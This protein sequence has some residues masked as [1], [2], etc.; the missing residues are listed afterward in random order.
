MTILDGKSYAAQLRQSLK[1]TVS[2]NGLSPT[3]CIINIGDDPASQVYVRNKDKACREV[4]ISCIIKH[5]EADVAEQDV[6]DY[7]NEV[8]NNSSIDALMVQ[9]PIPQHLNTDKIIN[10]ITPEKDVDGLTYINAGKLQ[11]KS[12]DALVPCTPLGIIKLLKHYNIDLCGKHCVVIGRS[13]IVGK[14]LA[15][16]LINEDATITVCHS[17]TK[18]LYDITR[19]ADI[20]IAA[21]GKP[22]FIKEYI[23]KDGAVVI[24][25]GIN[26]TENGLCGDVD[27]EDAKSK[28][29]YITPVPGGVGPM[30][31]AMLLN[32][33][34]M[35]TMKNIRGD[36]SGC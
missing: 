22:N 8:N 3:L 21:L 12:V 15:E 19:E 5:F 13:N 18:D 11:H 17:K 26:R 2:Q 30:T 16:L 20:V 10:S 7:I 35:A 25:V 27:F 32:N 24:D 4:G 6:L 36:K 23:I 33:V 9:L 31:V 1:E 29:S 28:C 14:P 34:V